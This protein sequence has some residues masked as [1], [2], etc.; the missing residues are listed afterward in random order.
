LSYKTLIT[1]STGF[2]GKAL[3]NRLINEN[4][5]IYES[6]SS[7]ANL[8]NLENL[9]LYK[10]IDFDFIY[11]TAAIT[12]PG[13]KNSNNQLSQWIGNQ[14]INT[15]IINFWYKYQPQA[16]FITFGSS[17]MYSQEQKML[18]DNCLKGSPESQYYIYGIT[19][20]M[21]LEGLI[22]ASFQEKMSYIFYIPTVFYG[23]NFRLDDG[24]FIYD[25]IRKIYAGK[26]FHKE[27]VLWGDGSQERDLLYIDD[28]LNI[29]SNTKFDNSVINLGSGNKLKIIEYAYMISKY[30]NYDFNLIKFDL[31]KQI[32]VKKRDL[33]LNK[34][35]HSI[36]NIKITNIE[37]GIKKTIDFF[38]NNQIEIEKN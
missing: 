18:E 20:R 1:G 37:I 17:C 38:L 35:N 12:H 33:N 4:H 36:N 15:N 16:K 22:A 2:L 28:A 6:N 19:K 14:L 34:L 27:V 10:N 21:L 25:L 23:P 5:K 32:G 13:K 24:H 30:L 11:H 26:Y 3:K 9:N 29:I 7:I 8:E 31:S